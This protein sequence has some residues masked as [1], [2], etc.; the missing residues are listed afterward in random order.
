MKEERYF[1]L[2]QVMLIRKHYS[3]LFRYEYRFDQNSKSEKM[4]VDIIAVPSNKNN[5]E[6]SAMVRFDN[7]QVVNFF[8]FVELN[9]ITFDVEYYYLNA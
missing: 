1:T 2:A 8:L 3:Y 5:N 6:Y 4:V 9:G 7:S